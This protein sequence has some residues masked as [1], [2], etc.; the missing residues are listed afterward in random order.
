LEFTDSSEDPNDQESEPDLTLG[1]SADDVSPP[2]KPDNSGNRLAYES[3]NQPESP[4]SSSLTSNLRFPDSNSESR[5]LE[6]KN[7]P[8]LFFSESNSNGDLESDKSTSIHFRPQKDTLVTG[9]TNSARRYVGLSQWLSRSSSKTSRRNEVYLGHGEPKVSVEF[10]SYIDETPLVGIEEPVPWEYD[11]IARLLRPREGGT[12]GSSNEIGF[13]YES[14]RIFF[15][16]KSSMRTTETNVNATPTA[17]RYDGALHWLNKRDSASIPP[18]AKTPK[19]RKYSNALNWIR[20]EG[21]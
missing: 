3:E 10:E 14:V 6:G 20:N 1:F 9:P 15:G 21:R 2:E 7:S 11:S 19:A 5:D 18:K 12:S 16:R 4:L 17:F 13:D 8:S